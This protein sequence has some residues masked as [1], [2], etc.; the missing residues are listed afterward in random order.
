MKQVENIKIMI[1]IEKMRV[2]LGGGGD[3]ARRIKQAVCRALFIGNFSLVCISVLLEMSLTPTYCPS[4][5]KMRNE[6]FGKADYFPQNIISHV[7][8]S[9]CTLLPP[10]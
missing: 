6:I 10:L 8:L 2:N 7:F 9:H 5:K 3:S 1:I 4:E